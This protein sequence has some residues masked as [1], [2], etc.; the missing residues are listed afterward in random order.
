LAGEPSAPGG[1]IPRPPRLFLHLLKI[2]PRDGLERPR[3]MEHGWGIGCCIVMCHRLKQSRIATKRFGSQ[4]PLQSFQTHC[5]TMEA[6]VLSKSGAASRTMS[7]LRPTRCN[8]PVELEPHG[9]IRASPVFHV[10]TNQ[11]PTPYK[12]RLFDARSSRSIGKLKGGAPVECDGGAV[13]RILVAAEGKPRTR[14]SR[15]STLRLKMICR[16]N[17]KRGTSG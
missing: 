4:S 10:E 12:V 9:V 17:G 2:V 16:R 11:R 13:I 8:S 6:E 15:D 14:Q 3:A 7:P 1:S 5:K